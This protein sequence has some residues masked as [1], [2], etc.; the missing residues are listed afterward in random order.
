MADNKKK[1]IVN[2]A[3][4]IN[5]DFLQPIFGGN[6][7]APNGSPEKDGH[8]HDGGDTWG[9]AQKINLTTNTTNR[10]VLQDEFAVVK[11]LSL[12]STAAAAVGTSLIWYFTLPPDMD[13]TKSAYFSFAWMGDSTDEAN[14][15]VIVNTTFQTSIF[16][17][18]WQWYIPGYA[19]FS[20]SV[21]Y[22]ASPPANQITSNV[23]QNTLTRGRIPNFTVNIPPFQMLVN[24]SSS[25]SPNYVKL[26]GLEQAQTS[27][28]VGVQVE[29]LSTG[30]PNGVVFFNGNLVYLSKVIGGSN[31]SIN[32]I[33]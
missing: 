14:S 27:V 19:V 16:R 6:K 1:A 20:P 15:E 33:N 13:V 22:D 23:N 28:M 5:S 3:T 7:N 21:I 30:F 2:D 25:G 9:H 12:P 31:I 18:T 10:L 8:L 26:T 4:L 29:V 17:I 11:T 24:D 32:S